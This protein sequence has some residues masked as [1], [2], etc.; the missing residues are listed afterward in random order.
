M[1]CDEKEVYKEND[2]QESE[3]QPKNHILKRFKKCKYDHDEEVG[4]HDND[5]D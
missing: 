4:R 2:N 3:D 1:I 5:H